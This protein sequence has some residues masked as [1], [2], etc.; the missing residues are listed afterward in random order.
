[1][2]INLTS[3]TC[4]GT[5]PQPNHNHVHRDP[6]GHDAKQAFQSQRN[7]RT[8]P[9]CTHHTIKLWDDLDGP[10]RLA[11]LRSEAKLRKHL[12]TTR[13][14]I[15]DAGAL[16]RLL[17]MDDRIETVLYLSRPAFFDDE[18]AI[19]RSRKEAFGMM[20]G[21]T[22]LR[23]IITV[24]D[25]ANIPE[26]LPDDWGETGYPNVCFMH[27]VDSADESALERFEEFKAIPATYRMLELG[28]EA[29]PLDLA[30]RLNGIHGVVADGGPLPIDPSDDPTLEWSLALRDACQ[31]SGVA[32]YYHSDGEAT[33]LDG[34]EWQESPF[35]KVDLAREPMKGSKRCA[36]LTAAVLPAGTPAVVG[37]VDDRADGYDNTDDAGNGGDETGGE[38][39]TDE[40]DDDEEAETDEADQ[41][42][43]TDETDETDVGADVGGEEADTPKRNQIDE[44]VEEQPEDSLSG[45]IHPS[46]EAALEED[47]PGMPGAPAVKAEAEVV[48][49]AD[50]PAGLQVQM[51]DTSG[52]SESDR[53]DF[54]HYN[55]LVVKSSIEAGSALKI[56]HDRK[57]YLAGGYPTW[58]A[59]IKAVYGMTRRYANILIE[60]GA[61][62]EDLGKVGN[63]F[64]TLLPQK[65]TQVIP[66]S[67]LKDSEVRRQ[68][69]ASAIERSAGGLPA[70]KVIKQV[71]AEIMASE[72]KVSPPASAP[73]Q[74]TKAQRRA[75]LI[76]RLKDVAHARQSW[77]EVEQLLAE[78]ECI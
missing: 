41:A 66:L 67:R 2:S 47:L 68:A 20:R 71:V 58:D 13:E 18:P 9:P 37:E 45:N 36:T 12:Q 38:A 50:V 60:T 30:N 62:V 6:D 1:M 14:A 34:K 74:E 17:R 55:S 64:P 75:A 21:T 39:E 33:T 40:T 69:W 53:Q 77:D 15:K 31:E 22:R 28:P 56:I 70:P 76:A 16:D 43:E 4:I 26:M 23:H 27:R 10:P 52:L 59:Y 51:P 11:G 61:T 63:K 32:F 49:N 46:N 42:D 72:A 7:R 3:P 54:E 35:D 57:L 24:D 19:V 78:L 5:T 29:L 65:V 25:L 73:K 44:G 8:D 48:A